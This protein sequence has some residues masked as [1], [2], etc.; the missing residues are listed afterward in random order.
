ML[1][2]LFGIPVFLDPA[3]DA[4]L[5]SMV[6]IVVFRVYN[7]CCCHCLVYPVFLDPAMDNVLV[8]MFVVVIV[9]FRVHNV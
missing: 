9:V 1:L 6:V 2:S 4:V 8:S 7:V 3:M 5:V